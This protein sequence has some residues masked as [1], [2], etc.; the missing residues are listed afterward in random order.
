M[1]VQREPLTYSHI[2]R[3][4]LGNIT[5]G[6]YA[7]DAQSRAKW[8]C[9][10]ADDA[11]DWA[12]LQALSRSLLRSR[13][14]IVSYLEPSRR[15]GHLWLFTSPLPGSVARRFAKYLLLMH[16][17]SQVEVYPKQDELRTGPGSLVRLP[18]GIHRLDQ[19]RHHFVML[20]GKPLAP[21]IREQLRLLANPQRIPAGYIEQVVAQIPE[22]KQI[23]P[24]PRF[25][26]QDQITGNTPAERI[27]NAISVYDFVSQYV[28]LDRNG[29]GYCPFH[30][31]TH[32]SLGISQDGN[33]W[34]CF[35]GCGGGSIIDFY[36]KFE[37]KD[38]K[39]AVSDL[40]HLL[41]PPLF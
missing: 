32:M 26:K 1:A 38:F 5:L 40:A 28:E 2:E 19:K 4:L 33:F 34:H 13:D 31:D 27:K 37:G 18:L 3:H 12:G 20:E 30:D 17:L 21:S 22:S 6:A 23:F 9:L 39:Q 24:A 35:A 8:I 11:A 10:D 29:K 25:H 36:M 15:G 41:L 16:D 7:L 14:Q